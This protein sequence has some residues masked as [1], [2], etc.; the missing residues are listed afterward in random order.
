MPKAA[1]NCF[2]QGVI[3]GWNPR[4]SGRNIVGCYVLKWR[5]FAHSVVCRWSLPVIGG[6]C[7]KFK[8][9]QSSCQDLSPVQTDAILLTSSSQHCWEFLRLFARG[10]NIAIFGLCIALL[11]FLTFIISVLPNFDVCFDI[12]LL[13]T[14]TSVKATLVSTTELALT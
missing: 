4:A 13:Q 11:H 3:Y 8:T 2:T 9:D 6:H 10:L 5:P 1:Q 14:L 7:A 12:I